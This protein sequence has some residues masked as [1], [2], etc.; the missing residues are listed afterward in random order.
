MFFIC[1]MTGKSEK[2]LWRFD[3]CGDCLKR[4][5]TYVWCVDMVSDAN[6]KL[7][8]LVINVY[9]RVSGK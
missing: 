2:G 1:Y 3:E 8:V 9:V 7:F 4:S 5:D 6:R